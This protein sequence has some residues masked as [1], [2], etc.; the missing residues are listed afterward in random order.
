M[1]L[2]GGEIGSIEKMQEKNVF[3]NISMNLNPK[4]QVKNRDFA[5][6]LIGYVKLDIRYYTFTMQYVTTLLLF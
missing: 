4:F 1:A 6:N 2:V 5:F 3:F